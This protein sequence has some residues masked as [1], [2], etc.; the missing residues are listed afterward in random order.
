MPNAI[1]L[2][3]SDEIIWI[4]KWFNEN[5]NLSGTLSNSGVIVTTTNGNPG[6]YSL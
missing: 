2:G 3:K 1:A 5:G 4:E 6:L